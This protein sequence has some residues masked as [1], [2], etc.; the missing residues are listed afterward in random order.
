MNWLDK[1]NTS[2]KEHI[3]MQIKVTHRN[4]EALKNA[5]NPLNVQLWIAIGNLSQQIHELSL[6]LNYVE[7]ALQDMNKEA[8]KETSKEEDKQIKIAMKKIMAEKNK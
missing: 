3:E 1:V 2:I 4:E 8:M 7:R 6:K 5:D